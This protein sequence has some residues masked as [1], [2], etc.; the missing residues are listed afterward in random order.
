[1]RTIALCF[2]FLTTLACAAPAEAQDGGTQVR[3]RGTVE[4]FDGQTLAVDTR[5]E[6]S[7][8][9]ELTDEVGI[10]GVAASSI[11]DVAEGRFIGTTAAPGA[12][13]RWR[14]TEVHI[15][16][17]EMRGAGEGHY[18]WDFPETTMTNANVSGAVTA[19]DG[20]VLTLSYSGGEVDVVIGPETDIVTLIPGDRSLLVPG[21]AVFVLG[22]LTADGAFTPLALVAET[23][24]VEP[25]M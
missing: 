13:G 25:P 22:L 20:R 4:A 2:S 1:M 18:P 16:P 12:D 19:G 11:A 15:F 17:E 14:A 5:E 24:G 21:A 8:E 6:G 10:N 23:D 7:V 3:L 9:F